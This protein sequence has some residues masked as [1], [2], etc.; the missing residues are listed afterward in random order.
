METARTTALGKSNAAGTAMA[1]LKG[2]TGTTA[3]QT[4][5]TAHF[6]TLTSTQ[7]DTATS[8]YTTISGRLGNAAL[9]ACGAAPAQAYCGP[10]QNWCAGTP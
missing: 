5:L 8:R 9:F 2:G 4:A 6:G 3:Q 10:P 7:F 1:A